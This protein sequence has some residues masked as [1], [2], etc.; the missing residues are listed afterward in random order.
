MNIQNIEKDLRER[1]Q[2]DLDYFKGGM[3]ERYAIAWHAYLAALA[4]WELIDF[5]IQGNLAMMLPKISEPDPVVEILIGRD[6]DDE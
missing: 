4:E 3:P 1:I 5:Q 2:I 6:E